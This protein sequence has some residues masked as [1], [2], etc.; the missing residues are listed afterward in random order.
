[1]SNDTDAKK[2]TSVTSYKALATHLGTS[3]EAVTA[4]KDSGDLNIMDLQSV[5]EYVCK[6]KGWFFSTN[7][8]AA[9]EKATKPLTDAEALAKMSPTVRSVVTDNTA[10]RTPDPYLDR[11]RMQRGELKR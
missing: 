9:K 8:T 2:F 10:T 6:V 5:V 3:H 7:T 11:V 4:A 1:M